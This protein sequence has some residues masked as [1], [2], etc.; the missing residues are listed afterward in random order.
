MIGASETRACQGGA[1]GTRIFARS[2]VYQIAIGGPL[3][4]LLSGTRQDLACGSRGRGLKPTSTPGASLRDSRNAPCPVAERRSRGGR[5]FQPGATNISGTRQ[6]AASTLSGSLCWIRP[7]H[8]SWSHP[9]Q[10]TAPGAGCKILTGTRWDLACRSPG[11]DPSTSFV[12]HSARDDGVAEQ[13]SRSTWRSRV[14]PTSFGR[15]RARPELAEGAGYV[16]LRTSYV[17]P[18]GASL[19]A[20][21]RDLK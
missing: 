4:C 7:F 1:L 17:I 16:G 11:R 3:R 21:S 15:L 2:G 18:S 14:V 5:G 10:P 19:R 8:A 9:F 13:P 12:P 20:Q 6:A